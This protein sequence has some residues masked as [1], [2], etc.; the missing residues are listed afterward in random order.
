MQEQIDA[1]KTMLALFAGDLDEFRE[2]IAAL[3]ENQERINQRFA[4]T[5]RMLEDL[6]ARIGAKGDDNAD[7]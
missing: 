3:E 2:R 1:I 5:A 4:A 6:D 7:S